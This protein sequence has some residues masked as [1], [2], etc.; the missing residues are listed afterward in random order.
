M[1]RQK[2]TYAQLHCIK[3]TGFTLQKTEALWPGAR[4]GIA[5]SGGVDSFTLLEV[6]KIRQKIVPFDFEIMAL[7]INPGFDPSNHKELSNWLTARNIPAHIEITNIGIMAHVENSKKSACFLCAWNR[8]K[9]LFELCAKYNLTHLA[10]GHNADD[11]LATFLLNFCRNGR[12]A[13][14]SVNESFFK[15]KLRVIR[16][17]LLVEKKYISQAA[18][19]WR[20]PVFDNPCPSAG[21]TARASAE[22][23]AQVMD[24]VLPNARRSM[25]NALVRWQLEQESQDKGKLSS[26]NISN[27]ASASFCANIPLP[28][29][30]RR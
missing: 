24:N 27:P 22:D 9:R 10:F 28:A 20:L 1:P 16:P 25:L 8:R 23:M 2:Y 15:G 14:L 30:K 21:K 26:E 7:H 11:M 18:R 17:L 29:H 4:I 3:K 5:L 13:A 6:M 12:V 19:Q